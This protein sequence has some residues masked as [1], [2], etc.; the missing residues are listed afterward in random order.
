LRIGIVACWI[1]RGQGVLARQL[2]S[3]LAELGHETFVLARPWK[4]PWKAE[5]ARGDDVWD[6]PGVTPASHFETPIGEYMEWA[7]A[8]GI[9]VAFFD[10]NYQFEEV[11]ALRRQ[12]VKTVGRFVWESFS[13]EHVEPALMAYDVIYSLTRCEQER[14]WG[15]GIE[16]PYVAWGCHPELFEVTPRRDPER[17]TFHYHAGLLGKRKPY[18]E[19][20]EAFMRTGNPNLRLLIKAQIERHT[21]FL[22]QAVKR[23][24]RIE[25][26]IADLQS[27]EHLQLFA[28]S[29]VCLA[30]ARWEG[31]GVHLYEA[32]AFGMP[33][34]TNDAPPM[35]ELVEDGLNGLLV[36]SRQDGVANS[37]IP[38]Y[39]PDVEDLANAIERLADPELRGRLSEGSREMAVRRSWT[40]T[41]SDIGGL[42]AKLSPVVA[43]SEES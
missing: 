36:G 5:A 19:V 43:P 2:R 42:L 14:Y 23:D 30:P 35:N 33:I 9:E 17:V 4:G 1:N 6:Q 31:L 37:G 38:A 18:R 41:I 34:I 28:D 32:I 8:T 40:R 25:P 10:Q 13:T 12:G 39:A 29:D 20:V 27:L 21:E 24:P 16:S 7:S 3:A 26:I 11:A 22:S 15:F